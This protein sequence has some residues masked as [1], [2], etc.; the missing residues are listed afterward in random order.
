MGCIS[1]RAVSRRYRGDIALNRAEIVERFRRAIL[2]LQFQGDKNCI[3]LRRQKTPVQTGLYKV[4]LNLAFPR[5]VKCD[6]FIAKI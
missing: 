2:K 4:T 1:N 6:L 3:E 5:S